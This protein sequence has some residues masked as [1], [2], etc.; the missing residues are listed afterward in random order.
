MARIGK[1]AAGVAEHV[2]MDVEVK[3]GALTRASARSSYGRHTSRRGNLAV[4]SGF[5][6]GELVAFSNWAMVQRT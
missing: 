5:Q 3:S 1:R 6:F 2:D 4:P